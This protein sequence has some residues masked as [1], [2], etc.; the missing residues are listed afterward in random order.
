[1]T[2]GDIFPE[3]PEDQERPV[4]YVANPLR[5]QRGQSY[6]RIDL[7]ALA[8]N[9]VQREIEAQTLRGSLQSAHTRITALESQVQRLT[10]GQ[11]EEK[12]VID[13]MRRAIRALNEVLNE[14]DDDDDDDDGALCTC[15]NCT[16][17]GQ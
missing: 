11:G 14:S 1:M 2:S 7:V 13:T 9:I 3:T 17:H 8:N 12:Q 10:S 5:V 4:D 15:L 16:M 6:V